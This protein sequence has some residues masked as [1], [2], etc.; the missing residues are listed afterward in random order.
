MLT[1]LHT[2]Y[3]RGSYEQDRDFGIKVSEDHG[4]LVGI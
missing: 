1:G 4:L 2:T 3:D